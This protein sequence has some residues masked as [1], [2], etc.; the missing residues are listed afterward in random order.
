MLTNEHSDKGQSCKD[1]FIVT[2][3]EHAE[4]SEPKAYEEECTPKPWLK[5]PTQVTQRVPVNTAMKTVDIVLIV[6]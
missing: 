1:E 4:K 6:T 5:W 3:E 2:E